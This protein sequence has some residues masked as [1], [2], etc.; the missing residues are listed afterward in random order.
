[1]LNNIVNKIRNAF[2][3]NNH[4]TK[5]SDAR[6]SEL[7]ANTIAEFYK[8]SK[9][10][11]NDNALSG[12]RDPVIYGNVDSKETILLMDDQDSVFYLY[13]IDFRTIL[14]RYNIDLLA[15]FKIVRCDGPEAGFIASEYLDK[16]ND[17]IV[18]A[19]LDLTLGKIIKSDD[20]KAIIHDGVDVAL[21]IIDKYP[22]C[23]I[24]LCTAHMLC[25]TNP[26]I[27]PL[28]R[29]FNTATGHNLLDYAFSKNSDRAKHIRD[30]ILAIDNNDYTDYGIVNDE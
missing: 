30:M 24:G 12:L 28:I 20:G 21:E 2:N 15:R 8:Q 11:N 1:M 14:N 22:K 4:D 5:N 7:E 6:I 17:D 3:G 18:I 13:D 29:K 26:A 19:I 9:E 10:A 27:A 16:C 23:K 25:D